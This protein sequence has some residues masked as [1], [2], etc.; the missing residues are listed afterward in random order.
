M[1]NAWENTVTESIHT[2]STVLRR[3]MFLC[4]LMLAWPSANLQTV[5]WHCST[6]TEFATKCHVSILTKHAHSPHTPDHPPLNGLA[7][8]LGWPL[9]PAQPLDSCWQSP[10]QAPILLSQ[11]SHDPHTVNWKKYT[12]HQPQLV[13][14]LPT[15]DKLKLL[16]NLSIDNLSIYKGQKATSCSLL[17]GPTMKLSQSHPIPDHSKLQRFIGRELPGSVDQFPQQTISSHHLRQALNGAHI[18]CDTQINLLQ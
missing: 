15:M 6:H 13:I 8:R 18:S 11:H 3:Q 7:S 4:S 14:N 5:S 17:R 1:Q 16:D 10:L 9:N 12:T 2:I